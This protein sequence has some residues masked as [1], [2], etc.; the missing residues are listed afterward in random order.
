MRRLNLI[1]IALALLSAPLTALAQ[2]GPPLQVDAR[3]RAKRTD[4]GA[5]FQRKIQPGLATVEG[6]LRNEP[7]GETARVTLHFDYKID[8]DLA[9][10]EIISLIVIS[11]EDADGK[12]FSRATIDPNEVNLNPNRVPLDYSATLY[13]PPPTGDGRGYVVR[14]RVFGNYE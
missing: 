13:K 10:D 6:R 4:V 14:V 1:T 5:T 8:G 9:L 11:L 2:E 3:V 12:E 7:G